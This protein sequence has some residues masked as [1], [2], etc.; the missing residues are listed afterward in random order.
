MSQE[1]R[2][3]TS[4]QRE[5]VDK[6]RRVLGDLDSF[7]LADMTVLYCRR[8]PRRCRASRNC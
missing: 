6:A 1:P 2:K 3:L 7:C 8:R 4:T 5:A